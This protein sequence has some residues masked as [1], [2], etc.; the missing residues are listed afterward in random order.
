M[1][2]FSELELKVRKVDRI[3]ESVSASSLDDGQA[4]APVEVV[5]L[6]VRGLL[7]VVPTM[8]R[9]CRGHRSR[10]TSCRVHGAVLVTDSSQRLRRT[11]L[12]RE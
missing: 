3:P 10:R 4:I 12:L 6:V 8:M 9:H 11:P 7:D 2:S 1:I 5:H